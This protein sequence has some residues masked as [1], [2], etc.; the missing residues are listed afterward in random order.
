MCEIII[1]D[2]DYMY[3]YSVLIN[4]VEIDKNLEYSMVRRIKD[5]DYGEW[6]NR[7]REIISF[8]EDYNCGRLILCIDGTIEIF[9]R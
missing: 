2:Y 5:I 8:M 4:G 9:R 6:E 7:E 1:S 3:C